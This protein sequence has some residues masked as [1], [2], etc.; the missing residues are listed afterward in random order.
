VLSY[1]QGGLFTEAFVGPRLKNIPAVSF[2]GSSSS[3]RSD[4]D[5]FCSVQT[6]NNIDNDR[7]NDFDNVDDTAAFE[8]TTSLPFSTNRRDWM[9]NGVT[10]ST[11]VAGLV[12]VAAWKTSPSTAI[13]STTDVVSRPTASMSSSNYLCDASVSTMKNSQNGRVIHLIGTAHISPE[14]AQ[15]A[16]NIVKEVRPDAV[17]VELD[18]KRVARAVPKDSSTS[19]PSKQLPEQ[20]T[21]NPNT[22]TNTNN[23]PGISTSSTITAG[24]VEGNPEQE[25][26]KK[27]NPFDLKEKFMRAGSTLIGNSIK[28]LYKKL[29]SEGFNAGEEFVIAVR[30]GLNVGSTIILGD[31]DVEVTLRHITD[32]L[33]KTDLKR[34]LSADSEMEKSMGKLMPQNLVDSVSSEQITKDQFATYVETMKAKDNVKLLMATLKES[35]P[36]LYRALV[37][38]RDEFMADGLDRLNQYSLTVAVMG[39]AHVD[40]VEN[41]LKEKGWAV[42]PIACPLNR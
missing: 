27:T 16:G 14:S 6:K 25:R 40:G 37:S 17:F 1:L 36:E 7:K 18:A 26:L 20:D 39:I 15:L 32:A 9:I 42:V 22:A 38:E 33:S 2:L 23:I 3:R 28:G 12:G 21:T 34:L 31:R 13:A 19:T 8:K 41:N 29:E 10:T 5:T 35:A 24:P 4:D 11:T 30:E